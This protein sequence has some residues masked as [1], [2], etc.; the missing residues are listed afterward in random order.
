[1]FESDKRSPL[2]RAKKSLYSR[3]SEAHEPERHDIQGRET[4]NT[5]SG[6]QNEPVSND[7]DT[8][9]ELE[10]AIDMSGPVNVMPHMDGGHRKTYKLILAACGAFLVIALAIAGFSLLRGTNFVSANNIDIL[11][12]GPASVTGGEPILLTTAIVNKNAEKIELVDLII[13]FPEGAK[14]PNNPT[15]DLSRLRVSVGDIAPGQVVQKSISAIMFGQEGDERKVS[16]IVEYR[17]PN[18]NAIFRKE[19]PYNIRISSSPVIVSIDSLDRVLAGQATDVSVTVVSNSAQPMRD[20]LLSLDYPFGFQ[21]VPGDIKPA[22]GDNVWRI[23]DLAPGARRTISFKAI[24]SGE[25]GE[26][27][28]IH[29]NVGLRDE[30]NEREIATVIVSRDRAFV[31]ERP[32]LGIDLT[33]NGVRGDIATQPGD[34]VRVDVAWTNN[35]STRI[36]NA[37][38]EAKLTGNALDRKSISASGGYYDSARDVVIWEAGRVQGLASIAPGESSRVSFTFASLRSAPGQAVSNPSVTVAVSASGS[39][40]DELGVSRN[41]VTAV[42]R[43]ARLA[44]S[45]GITSRALY[46]QGAFINSGSIPP[47]VNKQT[48]YTIV[49]TVSNS[50]NSVS[51]AQVA[52]ILPQGVEWLGKWSPSDTNLSYNTV[53]GQVTWLIGDIPANSAPKQVSFQV[54]LVPSLSDVGIAPG[55][56]SQTQVTGTDSFAGVIVRSTAAALTTRIST[57]LYWKNGDDIVQP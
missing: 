8:N 45:I 2:D 46:S 50:S 33:F 18:S 29:A 49:W 28:V 40:T 15:K 16:F 36:D 3:D 37:R 24:V 56:L 54:G 57:D 41:V 27:R 1:M 38:I 43:T 5:P 13:Q 7:Q 10:Q 17:T 31:I 9:Q 35:S 39:R 4:H 53:G 11:I 51:D 30:N 12:E 25:D 34:T 6:W 23:G 44:S 14:D 26:E 47:Q 32:F 20:L 55:L 19:K 52:G 21:I 22:Y 48:T 42:T